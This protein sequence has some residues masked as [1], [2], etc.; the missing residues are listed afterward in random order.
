[1]TGVL[2]LIEPALS[3]HIDTNQPHHRCDWY[4]Y[5]Y[6]ESGGSVPSQ[7]PITITITR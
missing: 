5:Q 7:L 2:S 1:M 3:R 6:Q 4:Q